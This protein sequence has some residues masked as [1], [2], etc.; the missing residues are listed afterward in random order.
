MKS[1]NNAALVH[2]THDGV[3]KLELDG[4]AI[5]NAALERKRRLPELNRDRPTAGGTGGYGS[6]AKP[7][8]CGFFFT[9]SPP[10]IA[11]DR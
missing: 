8:T 11:D 2:L 6:V 9:L 5:G 1:P 7:W 10:D 4:R 3:Y